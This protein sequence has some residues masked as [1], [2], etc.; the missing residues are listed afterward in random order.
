[1]KLKSADDLE[2]LM[3]ANAYEAFC[4]E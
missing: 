3:V 1:M 2:S 4:Q